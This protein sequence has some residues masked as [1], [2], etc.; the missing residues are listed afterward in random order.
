[1]A[2]PELGLAAFICELTQGM[3]P[4]SSASVGPA[5]QGERLE[6]LEASGPRNGIGG[7]HGYSDKA[8]KRGGTRQSEVPQ[9]LLQGLLAP[10]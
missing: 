8:S 4:T 1:M 10:S 9:V 2:T 7:V 6:G 3:R 5:L